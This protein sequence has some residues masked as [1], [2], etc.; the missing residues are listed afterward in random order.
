MTSTPSRKLSYRL[1]YQRNKAQIA[2]RRKHYRA[3]KKDRLAAQVEYSLR[4]RSYLEA[5]RLYN[6]ATIQLKIQTSSREDIIKEVENLHSLYNV[7]ASPSKIA[8]IIKKINT[9]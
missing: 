4:K 2:A 7:R 9:Y 6:K 3:V 8:N 5:L 1:Y